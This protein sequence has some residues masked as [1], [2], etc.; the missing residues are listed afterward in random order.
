MDLNTYEAI[1]V[2]SGATG[3]M[4]AL[5]LAQQGIKVLVVEAGPILTREEVANNEPQATFQ[6]IS[7]IISNKIKHQS[8]HPGYW[9]NNP[10]LYANEKKNP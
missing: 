7:K 1:V 5:T 2:G 10:N 8:Q 4:V 6:R 3:G 9:K